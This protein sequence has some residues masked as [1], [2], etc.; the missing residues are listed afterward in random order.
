VTNP[1]RAGEL[2]GE[3]DPRYILDLVNRIVTVSV[4]TMAIVDDLPA[5]TS[6]NLTTNQPAG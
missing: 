3:C 1:G 4:A 6:P 5:L 2:A